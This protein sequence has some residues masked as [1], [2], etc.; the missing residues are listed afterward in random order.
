MSNSVASSEY[1]TDLSNLKKQIK[2]I[3]NIDDDDISADAL[4]NLNDTVERMQSRY[5]TTTNK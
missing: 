4:I 1:A 3:T 2:D 5:G